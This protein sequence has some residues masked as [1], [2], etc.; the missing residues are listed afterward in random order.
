M[1]V[2]SNLRLAKKSS[3]HQIWTVPRYFSFLFA[4]FQMSVVLNLLQRK[5]G[6]I[7][8]ILKE[9]TLCCKVLCLLRYVIHIHGINT[10]L[11][12]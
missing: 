6:F 9:N 3:A 8:A 2:F 10:T 12:L 5:P 7:F 1:P 4:I 11:H